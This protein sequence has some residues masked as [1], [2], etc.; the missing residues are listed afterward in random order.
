M[1]EKTVTVGGVQY[2]AWRCRN[3]DNTN[4]NYFK[5]MIG[6]VYEG[7]AALLNLDNE[8]VA[9]TLLDFAY[10]S[11]LT[12]GGSALLKRNEDGQILHKKCVEWLVNP[13]LVELSVALTNLVNDVNPANPDRALAPEPLPDNAD[14]KASSAAKLKRKRRSN[15]G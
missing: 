12:K 3:V 4:I 5:R 9:I 15:T 11:G 10:I 1:T 13:E 7:I 14:P 8:Q 2:T 6:L